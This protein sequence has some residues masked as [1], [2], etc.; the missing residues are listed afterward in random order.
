MSKVKG[1]IGH[2]VRL[3]LLPLKITKF[4]LARIT[5]KMIF[6]DNEPLVS[7]VIPTMPSGLELLESQALNPLSQQTYKN[8]G[9]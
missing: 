9:V 8:Y 2:T 4:R 1:H 3:I 7:V 5:G 6:N